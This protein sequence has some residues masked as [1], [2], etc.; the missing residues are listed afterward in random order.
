MKFSEQWLRTMADPPID[1]A[2]L[3]DALTMAGLEVEA[4]EPAGPALAGVV[5]A[6]IVDVTPHPNADKLRVC[7]VDAGEGSPLTIVCGAPNARAGMT[8]PLAR[9]AAELPGGLAIRDAAVRGVQSQG[10]LCSAKELGLDEDASGLM[11]LDDALVPGTPLQEALALDDVLLT[12]KLTPNRADCLSLAGVAREVAAVTGAKLA[13]PRGVV[14]TRSDAVHRVDV[15]DASACP[16]FASRVIEGVDAAAP[17]PA[18]MKQRLER[19]GIR[20]ISAIVDI[21]NYVMLELGQPLHAYDR[22]LLEGEL[23]VRFAQ[24]GEKL[25]LL[26]GETLDLQDDLLLVCDQ[27]KPLGL[28]GIMGGEYSGIA[29]TTRDVLL[30][31]AFWNPAVIQGRMRRLGFSSDAG[32]RF[33]RGV[34]FELPPH[35]VDRAAQ[36]MVEICGGRAGPL[37]DVK[38][39][40][41]GR[42]PVR[43]R[44]A[45]VRRLLGVE[46]SRE[47]IADVFTRLGF[48]FARD[49]DDFVVTPPSYRFDLSIEEDFVEEVARV[50]GYD[51][52]PATIGEH[53]ASMLAL[54][55][56]RR[57]LSALRGRMVARDW[58]EVVTFSFVD[59][60]V[61][62]ALDPAATPVRVQNPIAAQRDVMRTTLLPGLLE[63]LQTNVNRRAGRVRIFEIGRVFRAAR[64][65]EDAQPLRVGALAY[66]DALPEQWGAQPSLRML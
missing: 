52:I 13:V 57:P 1:S 26:N 56:S 44:S 21:T 3:A 34:D 29:P 4:R 55:E 10:M 66:G 2:A 48:G 38:H 9:V 58:Q 15:R 27:V 49:G 14:D 54:P 41:P 17:T 11:V 24:P 43:V 30:E 62:A 5:V 22:A 39:A 61:E 45:R 35:A 60:A 6:R 65:T 16:R 19:S 53:G 8:A 42:K 51:A 28:A 20:S 63:V 31:G 12:L 7:R 50:R 37:S 25:L 33:E 40:L 23:V 46:L 59:S 47:D 64:A 18:W 32:Y 36:L